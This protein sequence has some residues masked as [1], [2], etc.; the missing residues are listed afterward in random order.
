MRG[1]PTSD[2]PEGA[3]SDEQFVKS[4]LIRLAP[5]EIFAKWFYCGLGVLI[6]VL[7]IAISAKSAADR[8]WSRI[9]ADLLLTWGVSFVVLC[10]AASV[11]CLLGFLFGIPRTLQRA[12]PGPQPDP[13]PDQPSTP[14]SKTAA[15]ATRAF[16]S[17]TSLEEISDWLTKIIIGLGLVQ[18][19]TFIAYLYK[20]ALFAAAFVAAKDFVNDPDV[21]K[22]DA[23][24][25]SPFFFALIIASLIS[26]CLFAYLETRTRLTLLFVTTEKAQAPVNDELLQSANRPVATGGAG[27][28]GDGN[29]DSLRPPNKAAPP[30]PEDVALAK[31]PRDSLQDPKQIVGW[32]LA[33]ARTGNLQIAED[34]LR[35]A[36]Q[37]EPDNDDIRLRIAD[38]RRLR[39]N[40]SGANEMFME[41]I[42]KTTEPKKR[43]ELLR[44]ALYASLY[45]PPDEGFKQAIL[46]S[47]QL[48]QMPDQATATIYL[49]RAAAYGQ[50]YLW[51][52]QN[53]GK[54]EELTDARAKALEAVKKVVELAPDYV[55]IE[56]SLLRS[57]FDPATEGGQDGT[58][59]DLE[60]FKN[61]QD[62][63][64]V[65]YRDKP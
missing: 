25:A 65:I 63:K 26:G 33:Q 32:A 6:V 15:A 41:V 37:K 51:L 53:A 31:L 8:T 7:G 2:K 64:D 58:E 55:S 44:R 40:Y 45:I 48:L 13:K 4:V 27:G 34:A 61:E 56:R 50:K 20:A 14:E 42:N 62:F 29:L 43:A 35:D 54:P 57:L 59:N 10:A 9:F 36:L 52:K 24:Y 23:T 38:V 3:S 12:N 19:Q 11:G 1:M 22:Y 46:L 28:T 30:S 60:V 21:L 17:N 49:W 47:D 16:L 18:F 5:V 39:A